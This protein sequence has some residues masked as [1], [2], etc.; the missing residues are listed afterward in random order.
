MIK[1]EKKLII[2]R[3]QLIGHMA[4]FHPGV[5]IEIKFNPTEYSLEKRNTFSEATIPGLESPILQ[6]S[7][8]DSRTLSF[9]LLIDTY[10]Y[11]NGVDIRPK[12][13]AKLE[14]LMDVDGMFHAPPPCKVLWGSLEFIGVLESMSKRYLLFKDDGTP[15]RAR[16]TLSFK[17][18]VPIDLQLEKS[19][20]SSPDKHK[21]RILKEG[22]SLWHLAYREYGDPQQ[23][24][25]IAE[26]NGIDNPMDITPGSK[27]MLAPLAQ[28]EEN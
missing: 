26:T 27:I 12:Y 18:Y 13:I 1:S 6:F 17:E 7:S 23:W 14:S 2:I 19:P 11:D 3:G 4:V 24:R 8:G 10:A 21:V 9:E 20:R 16:V 22:D 5:P 28:T 15:V 25:F